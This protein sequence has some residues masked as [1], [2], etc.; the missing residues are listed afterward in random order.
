MNKVY[1]RYIFEK[2]MPFFSLLPAL[3]CVHHIHP[4]AL[5]LLPCAMRC[6]SRFTATRQQ[7]LGRDV[8]QLQRCLCHVESSARRQL[9]LR[10]VVLPSMIR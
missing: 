2:H 8:D 6:T 4:S 7:M 5:N 9:A 3:Q 1:L 10:F